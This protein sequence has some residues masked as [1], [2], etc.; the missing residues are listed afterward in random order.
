MKK[1]TTTT[2]TLK[3]K[4]HY[5]SFCSFLF[6]LLLLLRKRTKKDS[7]VTDVSACAKRSNSKKRT[8]SL[9]SL[10]LFLRKI[11]NA[12]SI[13]SSYNHKLLLTRFYLPPT[14]KLNFFVNVRQCQS[15]SNAHVHITQQQQQQ[16]QEEE[17]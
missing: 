17:N 2:A 11:Y 9:N 1:A 16:P 4:D 7:L 15:L 5:S 6:L 8:P 3:L 14:V 10:F 12:V 13:V